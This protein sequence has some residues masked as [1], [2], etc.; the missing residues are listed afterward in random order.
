MALANDPT[1]KA[2]CM[3]CTWTGPRDALPFHACRHDKAPTPEPNSIPAPNMIQA[4]TAYKKLTPAQLDAMNAIN[5]L[6]NNVGAFIAGLNLA[7]GVD[8]DPRSVAIAKTE[9][10]TGFMWL[11]RAVAKPEFF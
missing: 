10:Q 3:Q 6:R 7:P 8:A 4:P 5:D 1:V 9:L 2:F 11:S